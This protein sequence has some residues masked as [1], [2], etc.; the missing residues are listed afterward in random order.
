MYFSLFEWNWI[1]FCET[2]LQERS[3]GILLRIW[4]QGYTIFELFQPSCLKSSIFQLF[5]LFRPWWAPS[6]RNLL[7]VMVRGS[8]SFKFS[9]SNWPFTIKVQINE[10]RDR[11]F[12]ISYFGV[13][14]TYDRLVWRHFD[15]W[16]WKIFI[17]AQSFW[18]RGS[19]KKITCCF[20]GLHCWDPNLVSSGYFETTLLRISECSVDSS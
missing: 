13:I 10:Y 11:V 6:V 20:S 19:L 8:N 12:S 2:S 15:Q 9:E 18:S 16:K 4:L 5:Q 3:I 14:T 17:L 7:R 1:F